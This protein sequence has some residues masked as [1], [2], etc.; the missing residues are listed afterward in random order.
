MLA[1]CLCPTLEW[2]N[3]NL[4][5]GDDVPEAPPESRTPPLPDC[6]VVPWQRGAAPDNVERAGAGPGDACPA[7]DTTSR[8]GHVVPSERKLNVPPAEISR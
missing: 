2:E 3:C 1:P 5:S 4:P 7:G 6:D 8:L